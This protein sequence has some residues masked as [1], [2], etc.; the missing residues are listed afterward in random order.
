MLRSSRSRE[1]PVGSAG[2]WLPDSLTPACR[3][4]RWPGTRTAAEIGRPYEAVTLDDHRTGLVGAG[5]H[6]WWSYA[7]ASMMQSITEGRFAR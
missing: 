5:E 7:Y 3:W 2:G 4:S 6:P 1:R